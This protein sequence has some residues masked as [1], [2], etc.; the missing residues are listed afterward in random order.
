MLNFKSDI[1]YFFVNWLYQGVEFDREFFWGMSMVCSS[2]KALQRHLRRYFI[3]VL[4]SDD[5]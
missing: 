3:S 4:P 2:V 5:L 1:K